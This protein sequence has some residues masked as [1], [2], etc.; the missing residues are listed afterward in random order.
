MH[1]KVLLV[2]INLVALTELVPVTVPTYYN[3]YTRR[4]SDVSSQPN[5]AFNRLT[6]NLASD[7]VNNANSV[8]NDQSDDYEDYEDLQT[9][10]P[11]PNYGNYMG[12]TGS[13]GGAPNYNINNL[14]NYWYSQNRKKRVKRKKKRPQPCVPLSYTSGGHRYKRDT[15]NPQGDGKTFSLVL[16]DYNTYGYGGGGGGGQYASSFDNTNPQYDK[17]EYGL[18][19][20]QYQPYGGYPCI[21]ISFHRPHRPFRPSS[22][23]GFFGDGGLFDFFG[24][25]SSPP[26]IIANQPLR[27]PFGLVPSN[28]NGVGG[29]G[30]GGY[31]GVQGAQGTRPGAQIFGTFL[32]KVNEF[33]SIFW[34]FLAF[35]LLFLLGME[36]PGILNNF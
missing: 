1:S 10:K 12:G 17:P 36:A 11:V 22:G 7:S 31:P 14:Y 2:L 19:Q 4:Q 23:F 26:V 13:D 16:G 27:P 20:V 30:G 18:Q 35:E 8:Q 15:Y 6:N 34:G 28:D 29:V 33:V 3:S 32:D 25:D 21:P 5:A 9:D 24:G